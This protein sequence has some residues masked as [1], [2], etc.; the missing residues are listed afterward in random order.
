M[1]KRFSFRNFVRMGITACG[2]VAA[3]YG[4]SLWSDN[5]SDGL[6]VLG[7]IFMVAGVGFAI[8]GVVTKD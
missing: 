7:T 1:S 6:K 5:P 2:V 8:Y 4:A 3:V